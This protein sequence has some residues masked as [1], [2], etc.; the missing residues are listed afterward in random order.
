MYL[1]QRCYEDMPRGGAYAC[2][3]ILFK[4]GSSARF[5]VRHGRLRFS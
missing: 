5:S 1:L 2:A 4:C 3:K